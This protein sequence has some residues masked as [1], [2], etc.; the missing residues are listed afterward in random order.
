M[1]RDTAETNL[2]A[3]QAQKAADLGQRQNILVQIGFT[4]IRAPVAGRIGSISAKAGAIVRAADAQALATL[5]QIDPIYVASAI[6]QAVLPDLKAAMAKGPVAVEASVGTARIQGQV[7]FVEN[8]IDAGT[9]TVMLRSRFANTTETLWPG[10]FVRV[11][12][13]LGTDPE[14]LTVPL[15]A[16]QNGQSGPYVFAVDAANRAVLKTVRACTPGW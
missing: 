2:K 14:A 3:L 4:E 5:N 13:T 7:A 16:I 15:V 9:G 6:P 1:Q 12:I 10:A 8:A 11:T